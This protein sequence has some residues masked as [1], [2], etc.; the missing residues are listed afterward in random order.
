MPP[1][2]SRESAT[3]PTSNLSRLAAKAIL[4]VA[5]MSVADLA[6][7][8][9]FI[10]YSPY[11]IASQSEVELRGYRY[12]DSRPDLGGSAAEF[13][14]AHGVNDWWKPEVYLAKYEQTPSSGRR[15]VGFEF[16]NTFQLTAPGKYWADFGFL[17]SFEHNVVAGTPN[18]VEFGP[19]LA[20]TSGRF[21]HLA[22]L[23]WEKEV[24]GG[25]SGRYEF[26]YSYS[27]T[28]A[29]T[30]AFRPGL[31]AYGRPADHA[32][33]A[34][35]IVGGEWHLPGT[36]SNLEYRVG[37]VI[38]LNSDAPKQTWLARLEYEFL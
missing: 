38:G 8:D 5:P 4:C 21:A 12:S 16:E 14:I 6:Q 26:R 10:V 7:A 19:L 28:Y 31:E 2:L 23:I 22:N 37:V 17:A 1:D 24:G 27:G 25:A 20:T 11:V 34:G 36:A 18:A 29:V 32:Y 30:Q 9:D 33:Q 15:F 3:R 35:P 13:S